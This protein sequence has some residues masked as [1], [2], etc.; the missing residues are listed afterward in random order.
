MSENP[1]AEITDLGRKKY[2][3][4]MYKNALS[5]MANAE[6]QGYQAKPIALTMDFF[7]EKRDALAAE[8]KALEPEGAED[9]DEG[10]DDDKSQPN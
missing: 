6:L 5:F 9:Q 10:E 1:T 4:E 2:A 7:V 3:L 8:I